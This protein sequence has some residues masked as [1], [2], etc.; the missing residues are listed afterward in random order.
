MKYQP[1][2]TQVKGNLSSSKRL[3]GPYSLC[4]V[5]FPKLSAVNGVL[6]HYQEVLVSRWLILP[7]GFKEGGGRNTHTHKHQTDTLHYL[8]ESDYRSFS[9]CL[10]DCKQQLI[11]YLNKSPVC[12]PR[13]STVELNSFV[14][15]DHLH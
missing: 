5:M 13:S 6:Q 9:L 14:S 3:M 7:L 4:G 10:S 1:H 2:L 12:R 15:S 11:K 8:S